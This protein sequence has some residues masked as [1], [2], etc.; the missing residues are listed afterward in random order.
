MRE[1]SDWG[2]VNE[3]SGV[4]GQKATRASAMEIK[5]IPGDDGISLFCMQRA[6][7]LFLAT[8]VVDQDWTVTMTRHLKLDH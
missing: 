3:K 2:V 5:E 8:T 7:R 4:R 6:S 1:R